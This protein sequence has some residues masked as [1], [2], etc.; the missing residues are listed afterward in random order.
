MKYSA[1]SEWAL[2]VDLWTPVLADNPLEFVRY[3][4]PWGQKGTPLESFKGPRKW[5]CEDLDEIGQHIA[6]N[7]GRIALDLLPTMFRK[8]TVSGRG[9]GKSALVSWIEHWFMSTRVG[10]TTIVTANTEPQLR[11]KTWPELGKWLTLAM[12]GHWFDYQALSVK[13]ASWFA[14]IIKRDL[15]IDTGYYYAQALTWS[16]ENPDAFAGAHNPLGILVLMDEASGIAAK[17]MSVTEGFFT[18]PFP[19]RYWLLY[20]NGRR[21]TGYFYETHHPRNPAADVWRK[22]KLDSRTVEGTDPQQFATIIAKYGADSDEAR[23]E[24]YGQFPLEGDNQ[25]ISN[26]LVDAAQRREDRKDEGAALVMGVDLARL[27]RDSTVIRWRQGWDARS[28]RPVKLHSKTMDQ[29]EDIIAQLIDETNPDG[30]CIDAG[31]NG[32][33]LIDNLRRRGYKVEEVWF[34]GSA[35][36]KERYDDKITECYGE[37]KDWLGNGC[38]DDDT[39]LFT[40][41]TAREKCMVGKQADKLKLE[42]KAD[43]R[44]RGFESPD[45]GDALAITFAKKFARRDRTA[46]VHR[47][48]GSRRPRNVDFPLFGR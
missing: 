10:S 40:D 46:S 42:P 44:D 36:D 24:V 43:F 16:E 2:M 11:T 13:P 3:I 6:D 37:L 8:S 38:L 17:I 12:N 1:E 23:V 32:S 35:T 31:N 39:K 19:N 9:P 33:G 7:K 14:E 4:Y 18:E 25:F 28:H 22:R 29:Q 21:N 41:L 48:G 5:Q 30:V 34:G 26:G 47:R 20:S 45:D 15:K 27:G